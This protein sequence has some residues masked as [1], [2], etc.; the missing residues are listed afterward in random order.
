M[1]CYHLWRKVRT[2]TQFFLVCL[3]VVLAFTPT[4]SAARPPVVDLRHRQTEVK[5]QTRGNCFI[6]TTVAA[7]EAQYKAQGYG[8]LDLSEHFSDYVA[9]LMFLE[10]CQFDGPYRTTRMRIP[11]AWECESGVPLFEKKSGTVDSLVASSPASVIGIPEERYMPYAAAGFE[12]GGHSET[13]PFWKKQYNVSTFFLNEDRL[14]RSAL[15]APAYYRVKRPVWLPRDD[16]KRPEAL[17]AVLASGHEVIWDF[18]V[19]GNFDAPVWQYTTPSLEGAYA[20]RFLI[21][22]YDRSDPRNP[23]FLAKNSWGHPALNPPGDD[24]T[25]IH[26]NYL[27]YGEWASYLAEVDRPYRMPELGFI[28]RWAVQFGP[29]SGT[30]DVYHIPGLMQPLFDHNQYKD[31]RGH[32][33]RE[34]RIGTFYRNGNPDDPYRVNGALRGDQIEAWIDFAQRAPRWD[35][36]NGWKLTLQLSRDGESMQGR[37]TPPTG[38]AQDASAT[39]IVIRDPAPTRDPEPEPQPKSE[40]ELA[41]QAALTKEA[42]EEEYAKQRAAMS[43]DHAIQTKWESL[44]GESFLGRPLTGVE[45]CPDGLGRYTHYERGSIYWSPRTPACAIYGSIRER[46][47]Q[48]GWETS[49]LGYPTSDETD[50]GASGRMNTFEHGRIVWFPEKGAWEEIGK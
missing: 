14:P 24:F 8:D 16:A 10:T 15:R 11:D 23:F 21:V 33:I 26:Y 29:H 7:M 6:Y 1:Y 28:G 47:A 49:A 41:P 25:R 17:E 38:R 50:Y 40:P 30:L 39:R 35:L 44:G 42:M 12:D 48:L 36:L 2:W 3:P 32:I 4:L 46:W 18:F 19:A 31:E 5:A 20:H 43:P 22:G 13:D 34:R 27:N 45:T 37:A 9:R